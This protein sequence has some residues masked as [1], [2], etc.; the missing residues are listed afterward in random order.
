MFSLVVRVRLRV[1]H[2][3]SGRHVELV[4]L[5]NGGAESPK[6]C[7][8]VPPEVASELGLWPLEKAYIYLVE[9]ASG[10][11]EVYV[12]SEAVELELLDE[13]GEVLSSVVA[14]LVIQEGLNE[15]LITDITIDELGIQVISFSRGL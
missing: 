6:P 4:V 7:I 1:K 12:V 3:R 14:D 2:R 9:E 13:H 8:V 15:P 11:S 10:I 5:A